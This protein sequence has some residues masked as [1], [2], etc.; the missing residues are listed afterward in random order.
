M[1]SSSNPLL[2]APDWQVLARREAALGRTHFVWHREHVF[3]PIEITEEDRN[4][5]IVEYQAKAN[6]RGRSHAEATREA[7]VEIDKLENGFVSHTEVDLVKIGNLRKATL[8]EGDK[9]SGIELFDGA[10]QGYFSCHPSLDSQKT[11]AEQ[12]VSW[13]G[14]FVPRR[15]SQ[16]VKVDPSDD[17]I[18]IVQPGPMSNS[19]PPGIDILLMQMSI[20]ETFPPESSRWRVSEDSFILTTGTSKTKELRLTL[21]KTTGCPTSLEVTLAG[22]PKTSFLYLVTQTQNHAGIEVPCEIV[23]YFPL[24]GS[25]EKYHG[26]YQLISCHIGEEVGD[27]A[28]LL[29]KATEV[30]DWRHSLKSPIVYRSE[31]G[32]WLT[33]A[34]LKKLHSMATLRKFLVS[35]AV[36]SGVGLAAYAGFSRMKSSSH[37][38]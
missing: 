3:H 1:V 16:V 8:F 35:L 29:P 9:P 28:A 10:V 15:I 5:L 7:V 30:S 31:D 6:K 25:P 20:I 24:F 4:E 2:N 26:K 33:E 22:T 34:E 19:A 21:S 37:D 17:R 18:S 27:D 23:S 11:D 36:A 12:A 14:G 32:K 13:Q 38:S